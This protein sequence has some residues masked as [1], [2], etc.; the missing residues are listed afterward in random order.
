[1]AHVA[2]HGAEVVHVDDWG[3]GR[4]HGGVLQLGQSQGK[5]EV[6]G[7]SGGGGM[8]S[9]RRDGASLTFVS[10]VVLFFANGAGVGGGLALSLVFLLPLLSVRWNGNRA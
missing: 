9:V 3:G 6:E 10:M 1:M 7:H 5:G 2:T 8:D 4:T